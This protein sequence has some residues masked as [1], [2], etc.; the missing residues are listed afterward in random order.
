MEQAA[1]CEKN[2]ILY[3][4]NEDREGGEW[5]HAVPFGDETRAG[6][7]SGGNG[8]KSC[9][10]CGVSSGGYHHPGCD[11]EESPATGEQL[12]GEVLAAPRSL[13]PLH[14]KAEADPH[15]GLDMED[16]LE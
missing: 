13:Q 5:L 16:V 4:V 6:R 14:A 11:V 8:S 15:A 12:L 7:S 1:S 9:H 3:P 10:D 2:L